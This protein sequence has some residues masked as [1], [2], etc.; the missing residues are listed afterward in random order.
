[1]RKYFLLAGILLA[2]CRQDESTTVRLGLA[3]PFRESFGSM[4]RLGAELARDEINARSDQR[5]TIEFV[6]RDDQADGKKAA[7]I[8][9][10][11]VSDPAIVGVVGHVTS[12]AMKS[13]AKVY[14]GRLPAVAT[15]ASAPELTGI[16]PWAFRVIASDSANGVA[17]AKFAE[18]LGRKRVAILYE[19]NPYGRGL[20]DMFRRNYGGEIVSIDPIGNGRD[21][22][23][24]PFVAYY[25]KTRP[26]LVFVA[27]TEVPG[28][29][30]VR[31]IRRA[32]LTVDLMGG[33]GWTGMVT[34]TTAADG[35]YVGAPFTTED[36][37]PEAEAFVER[38]RAKY[39]RDPDAFAALGYDAAH[40][41]AAAVRKVGPDREKIREYLA[42]LDQSSSHAG[43]TGRI[44]F[45]KG[46]DPVTTGMVMTR[47]ERGVL[48]LAEAR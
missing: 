13:A 15:S 31:A 8:A 34:D 24:E 22:D 39:K 46:G 5:L 11:F 41:L 37:R 43:A 14:D 40:V 44:Y 12:G 45:T 30:L 47:V 19:N 1:M 10:A 9:E 3:G 25:Q 35:V 42:A 21:Q 16:S 29:P 33:D 20:A 4:T 27:S 23:F 7:E 36:S 38:F 17:L 6:I 32:G 2:G 18:K 28:L 48:K 26:D